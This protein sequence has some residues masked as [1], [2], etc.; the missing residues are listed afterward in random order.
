MKQNIAIIQARMGS[1]RLPGK[2][3]LPLKGKHVLERVVERLE[4]TENIDKIIVATSKEKQDDVIEK[5]VGEDL[6][7]YRGSEKN[8]QKRFYEAAKNK[9]ADILV[10]VTAD[11][12]LISPRFL[13]RLIEAVSKKNVDYSA[14][15]INRTFPRGV[16]AEAF[17]AESFETVYNESDEPRHREH[18]TS[19]Y[20]ENPEKFRIY[21]IESDDV[22]SDPKMIDRTDLRLTLD[23]AEDYKLIKRIYEEIEFEDILELNEV[24]EYIDKNELSEINRDIEQKEVNESSN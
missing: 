13:D 21:N 7:I 5:I 17:T 1:T 24:I 11:C 6:Q 2:T 10:R 9:N 4:K 14:A 22:F 8:V 3:M 18:V 19:Y 23:T 20:R 12:P 16:T 15:A